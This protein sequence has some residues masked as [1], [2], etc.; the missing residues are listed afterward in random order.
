MPKSL[1]RPSGWIAAS[2]L[3]VIALVWSSSSPA[4]ANTSGLPPGSI[5]PT[6]R[7][8]AIA[9]RIGTILEEAHFRRAPIDDKMSAQVYDRY[10]D[11]LDGQRS[12]FLASDIA[13]FAGSRLKFDDMI[14]TGDLE[15]GVRDLRALPAAQSRAHPATRSI[16]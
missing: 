11:L 15:P 13:D 7:Q 1:R 2:A 5:V 12:Y 10:L 4:P 16:C 3:T 6:D 14:R 9:R 8:R